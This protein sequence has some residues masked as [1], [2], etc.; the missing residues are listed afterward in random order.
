MSQRKTN[1]IALMIPSGSDDKVEI[2]GCCLDQCSVLLQCTNLHLFAVLI[3][4]LNASVIL[5]RCLC[6]QE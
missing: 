4:Y 6:D 2:G 1:G 3:F 5:Q